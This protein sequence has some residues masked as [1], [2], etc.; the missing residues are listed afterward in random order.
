MSSSLWTTPQSKRKPTSPAVHAI[1][2]APTHMHTPGGGTSAI[3]ASARAAA[4]GG[5]VDEDGFTKVMTKK[6]RGKLRKVERH[7]PRFH[8]DQSAFKNGRKIGIAVSHLIPEGV[9]EAD[10]KH[11]RDLILYINADA[12][13]P[14]WIF[15]EVSRST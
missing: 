9:G 2:P 8:F 10:D 11:I 13:K 7:R 14:N 4:G 1:S 3:S 5:S 15:A 6:E 12:Q